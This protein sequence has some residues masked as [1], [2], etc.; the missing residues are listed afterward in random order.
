MVRL[1]AFAI[2]CVLACGL[3]TAYS[4]DA[5]AAGIWPYGGLSWYRY[6]IQPPIL[7]D[8]PIPYYAV[9]P[10]VYY[11]RITPRPYGFSPYAYIPALVNP[12]LESAGQC[13]EQRQPVQPLTV[14]NEHVEKPGPAPEAAA[15]SGPRPL[16]IVNPFVESGPSLAV[17]EV[18]DGGV[19]DE[20]QVVFPTAAAESP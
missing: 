15:K 9:H 17:A 19:P 14:W 12:T 5:S 11:S 6:W 13:A 4:T 20:P 3:S 7:A 8:R 2:C 18:P 10:P 16:M 1:K